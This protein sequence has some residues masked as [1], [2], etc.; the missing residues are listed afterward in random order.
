VSTRRLTYMQT[1]THTAIG[2][3]A[4]RTVLFWSGAKYN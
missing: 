3:E 2:K 1:H 4:A